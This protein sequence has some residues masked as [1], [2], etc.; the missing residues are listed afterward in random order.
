MPVI[1]WPQGIILT[2]PLSWSI[3]LICYMF[4]FPHHI[5]EV[6]ISVIYVSTCKNGIEFNTSD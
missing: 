6:K 3:G 1:S 5:S 4:I 2:N